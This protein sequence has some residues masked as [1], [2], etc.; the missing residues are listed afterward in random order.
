MEKGEEVRQKDLA[1]WYEAAER[2]NEQR[3][4]R[5]IDDMVHKHFGSWHPV[6]IPPVSGEPFRK[7]DCSLLQPV[8]VVGARGH[9]MGHGE[10]GNS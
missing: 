8:R 5:E 7:V 6:P 3:R 1:E 9:Q 10:S 2:R 4:Q